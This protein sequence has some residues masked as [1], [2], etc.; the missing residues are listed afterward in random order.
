MEPPGKGTPAAKRALN[1]MESNW[2][3]YRSPLFRQARSLLLGTPLGIHMLER[4]RALFFGW[5]R[6]ALRLFDEFLRTGSKRHLTAAIRCAKAAVAR[7]P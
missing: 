6:E 7:R 2:R 4:E 5:R 3:F 1:V